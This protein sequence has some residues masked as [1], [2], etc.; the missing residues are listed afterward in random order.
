MFDLVQLRL[1]Q[2]LGFKNHPLVH[3]IQLNLPVQH[4]GVHNFRRD[5]KR[6]GKRLEPLRAIQ[7][8]G[9]LDEFALGILQRLFN[10]MGPVNDI[11]LIAH[12]REL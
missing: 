11:I 12:A 5:S 8:A 1:A 3:R 2:G 4:L 9:Q 6:L 10:R 7:G